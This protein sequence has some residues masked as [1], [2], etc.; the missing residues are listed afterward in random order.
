VFETLEKT[1]QISILMLGRVSDYM[2]LMRLELKLQGRNLVMQ[3]AGYLTAALF[4]IL[5]L[6]FVGIAII[7]SF[8][9]T[10]YR[11][12]AAWGVVVLYLLVA[13]IGLLVV[14]AHRI[15]GTPMEVI[16]SELQRDVDMVKESL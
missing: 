14:N 13:G 4:G 3:A 16:S 1:K 8:W 9:E 11:I 15:K 6:F 2:D 7:V 10:D 12:L 5:A